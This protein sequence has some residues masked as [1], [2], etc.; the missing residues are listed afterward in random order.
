MFDQTHRSSKSTVQDIT[1]AI[2][3]VIFGL[4]RQLVCVIVLML[5]PRRA[6]SLV[7]VQRVELLFERL[8]L[9]QQLALPFRRLL[10]LDILIY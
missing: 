2:A 6:S 9:K 7:L 5:A 1:S 10:G 3:I 8:E 4:W